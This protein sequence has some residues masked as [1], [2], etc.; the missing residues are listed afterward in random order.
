MTRRNNMLQH[1]VFLN[2][3]DDIT[4]VEKTSMMQG[5]AALSDEIDGFVSMHYGSNLDFENKTP[6][7]DYGFIMVFRDQSSYTAYTANEKHQA[8][9]KQLVAACHGGYEGITVFD[10]TC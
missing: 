5:L 8:I 6:E 7:Y 3:K 10:I 9:G 4:N 1:C 2:F